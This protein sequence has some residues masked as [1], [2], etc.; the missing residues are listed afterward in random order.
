LVSSILGY[1]KLHMLST[2]GLCT[3]SCNN[4]W[5]TYYDC[6]ITNRAENIQSPYRW[7][8]FKNVWRKQYDKKERMHLP[9]ASKLLSSSSLYGLARAEHSPFLFKGSPCKTYRVQ[10]K[11]NVASVLDYMPHHT[12][13]LHNQI[14][15]WILNYKHCSWNR[16][17]SECCTDNVLTKRR[18]TKHF[19]VELTS[20]ILLNMMYDSCTLILPPEITFKHCV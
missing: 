6:N 7:T 8:E 20:H 13:Y 12:T 1:Y 4:L 16:S 15:Y 14:I 18:F 5:D 17:I 11:G 2:R 3:H 10:V 9:T 19:Y